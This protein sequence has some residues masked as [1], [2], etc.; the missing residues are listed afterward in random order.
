[1]NIIRTFENILIIICNKF[2]RYNNRTIHR[3]TQYESFNNNNSFS[4]ES[5]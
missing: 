1:M 4:E 2:F 5:V 3:E